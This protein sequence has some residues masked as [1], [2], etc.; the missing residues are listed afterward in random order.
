[1]SVSPPPM[2]QS[3]WTKPPMSLGLEV[4]ARVALIEIGSAAGGAVT[5]EE[6][7]PVVVVE[8]AVGARHVLAVELRCGGTRRPPAACDGW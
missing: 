5:G 7:H 3:S 2:R 6:E 4:S 8:V 1:M